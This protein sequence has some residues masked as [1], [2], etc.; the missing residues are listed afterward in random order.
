MCFSCPVQPAC[1]LEER[2]LLD[3]YSSSGR[4]A[5]GMSHE[6]A[7]TEVDCPEWTGQSGQFYGGFWEGWRSTTKGGPTKG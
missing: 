3:G 7:G 5:A 1:R 6:V 2:E 4:W